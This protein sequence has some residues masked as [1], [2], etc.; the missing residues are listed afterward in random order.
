MNSNAN[1]R[2]DYWKSRLSDISDA[3]K[4]VTRAT[5]SPF[6]AS[7]G[8][9]EILQ[10]TYG[11]KDDFA[12]T[13]VYN[14]ACAAKDPTYYA[15]KDGK[16][17]VVFI[18]GA[19][20]GCELE[21]IAGAMNL[22]NIAETGK[23]LLG[24]PQNKIY[25]MVG[26]VRLLVVPCGNP[27]GRAR[28]PYDYTLEVPHSE[29]GKY[30]MGTSKTDV[31]Y[32]WPFCKGYQPIKE[33]SNIL[34][35]YYNDDGVNAMHGNFFGDMGPETKAILTTCH[36]EAPDYT[37]L[38]HSGGDIPTFIQQPW[39]VHQSCN[40]RIHTLDLM[41]EEESLR[42]GLN[43]EV[44]AVTGHADQ[45]LPPTFNLNSA[46]HHACGGVSILYETYSGS[47]EKPNRFNAEQILDMHNV[48]FEKTLE[49]ALK[50]KM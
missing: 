42:R 1:N 7:A 27:D 3:A 8:G 50:E 14:S 9:R 25:D 40:D 48:L 34:G 39:Y 45:A 13:A 15:H 2:P 24:N 26:R 17:P 11:E 41:I 38:L 46:I 29:S 16:K 36:A 37:I 33:Y 30:T 35:A 20:H 12:S 49:L 6:A 43:H 5:V 19:V 31:V 44:Q 18:V 47:H 10:F 21:G 22:I 28:F 4:T 32:Q 23:D